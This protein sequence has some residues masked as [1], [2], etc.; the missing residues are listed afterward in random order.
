MKS[1][2][3]LQFDYNLILLNRKTEK[4]LSNSKVLIAIS[5]NRIIMV[6]ELKK[7][8]NTIV[9]YFTGS[10]N[11]TKCNFNII[12]IRYINPNNSIISTVHI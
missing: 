6:D 7:C 3:I 4:L 9:I 1:T 2:I 12:N 10:S 11:N 5:F 8:F